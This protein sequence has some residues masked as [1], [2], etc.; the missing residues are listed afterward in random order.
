[1]GILSMFKNWRTTLAGIGALISIIAKLDG[2]EKLPLVLPE[3]LVAI[4]LIL[5]KDA[6][7]EPKKGI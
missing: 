1:M 6:K 4:G 3:I 2:L 7:D 5:A